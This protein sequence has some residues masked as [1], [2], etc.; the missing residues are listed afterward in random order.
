MKAKKKIVCLIVIL[1][2]EGESMGLSVTTLYITLYFS[3][4]FPFRSVFG[5][6]FNVSL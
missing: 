5:I 1:S 2:F 4:R 6:N 3:F